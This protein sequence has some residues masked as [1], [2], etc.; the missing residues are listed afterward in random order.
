ML[1]WLLLE[2]E[3]LLQVIFY[4]NMNLESKL[5][6]KELLFVIHFYNHLK[7][8]FTQ[9]EMCAHFPIGKQANRQGLSIGSMLLIRDHMQPL[10][11]LENL[12]LMEILHFFGQ[13][14]IIKPCNLLVTALPNMM[15]FTFREILW[16]INF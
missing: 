6:S 12:F 8:M 16:K 1:I 14:I 7:R 9:L 10:I 5:I 4:K 13:G 15:K 3:W 11:C 2:P